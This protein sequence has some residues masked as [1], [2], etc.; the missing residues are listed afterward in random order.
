MVAGA[1]N[2]ALKLMV[3]SLLTD[4]PLVLEN[5]PYLADVDAL[6]HVLDELG[7]QTTRD[8]DGAMKLSAATIRSTTASYDLVRKMRASVLVFGP[9]LARC[10]KARVSLPGG[11]AIGTR[12]VD[13][14]IKGFEAMGATIDLDD[15]YM[16]GAAH[17]GLKARRSVSPMSRSARPNT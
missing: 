13:L 17:D 5:V 6:E 11:C 14:H 7:V 8:G 12:P 10:G 16:V 15:G 2:A 4:K 1:K 9:L 3:A